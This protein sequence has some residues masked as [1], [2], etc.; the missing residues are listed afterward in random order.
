MD[1]ASVKYSHRQK[2]EPLKALCITLYR[3]SYPSRHFDRKQLFGYSTAS[4]SRIYTAV[5]K[6]LDSKF[7][8][9]LYWNDKRLTAT[10]IAEYAS[11]VKAK[12]GNTVGNVWAFVD[13]IRQ[14]VCRPVVEQRVNY[15]QLHAINY[16]GITAPDGLVVSLYRRDY[17]TTQ[18]SSMWLTSGIQDKIRTI[19]SKERA[20]E[21]A[22]PYLVY[23]DFGYSPNWELAIPYRIPEETSIGW[24]KEPVAVWNER[25]GFN[26]TMKM[27]QETVERSF[28][29]VTSL[30]SFSLMVKQMKLNQPHSEHIFPTSVLFTNLHS[31]YYRNQTSIYFDCAP[32]TPEEYL[33]LI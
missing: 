33:G 3:L 17:G 8:H 4:L 20:K 10:K 7:K 6:H 30:F 27:L 32:P 22:C 18:D 11:C 16:Q 15:S 1:M 19:F 2:P 5:M 14:K 25:Q 31:C 28:G 23:A 12:S 13:G 24:N 29:R 9:I 21:E 26:T